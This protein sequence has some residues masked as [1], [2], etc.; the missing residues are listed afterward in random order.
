MSVV[1]LPFVFMCGQCGRHMPL[2][3]QITAP[4]CTVYVYCQHCNR[5]EMVTLMTLPSK[6]LK[7]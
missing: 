7:P 2:L 3:K 5:T 4:D 1:A 6:V